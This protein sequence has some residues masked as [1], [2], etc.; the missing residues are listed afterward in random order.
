VS[1]PRPVRLVGGIVAYRD[2]ALVGRAIRSLLRQK[3]PWSAG[4]T[5]IWVVVAPDSIGTLGFARS[6]AAG[7]PRV[8]IVEEPDR[9]GK[10]AALAEIF[11]RADG[12]VLILLNGDAEAEPGSVARLLRTAMGA[13]APFGVM[14]RPV[15]PPNG[16]GLLYRAQ[17]L[18]WGLHHRLHAELYARG[19]RTHL[20]DE[21]LA[22]SIERLPP[23]SPGM[24]ND[25]ACL[26][27]W[28][29]ETGGELRYAA[30]AHVRVALPAG[31]T[32]HVAQRRRIYI[33]H[34]Q[35]YRATSLPDPTLMGLAARDPAAAA[36][37][38]VSEVRRTRG[39]VRAFLL[40]CT[41]ELLAQ[42]LGTWDRLRGDTNYSIWPRIA[43]ASVDPSAE[44][45]GRNAAG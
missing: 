38:I 4:W 1:A 32:E 13:R 25:G 5:K 39:G 2:G 11:R 21:M 45:P 19:E 18:L 43:L 22:L 17:E 12:D 33:G 28:I 42:S 27:S 16:R 20:A 7:D 31:F 26:G 8:E 34:R 9:R 35:A 36:R 10:A 37:L 41:A 40:L 15:V 29:H 30:A 23:I 14:A 24:V 6:A 44:L 3:L